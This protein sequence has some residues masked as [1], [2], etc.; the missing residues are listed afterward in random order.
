M[1]KQL[2]L[3]ASPNTAVFSPCQ[4]YRYELRRWWGVGADI[5]W[6]ML[7]P[8]TATAETDDP[9]IRKITKFSKDWGFGGLLVGNLYAWRATDPDVLPTIEEPVG[10]DNDRH[11]IRIAD[12]ALV[13]MC[14]WGTNADP[15]RAAHV[16]RLLKA[17]GKPLHCLGRNTDGSPCHPLYK[18]GHLKPI[19]LEV[20]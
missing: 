9:T 8:S 4:R 13:I 16:I 5:A 7:N 11:L 1:S 14:A 18:P 10:I 6:I 19:P 17:T 15:D 3:F 2:G 20:P 12:E